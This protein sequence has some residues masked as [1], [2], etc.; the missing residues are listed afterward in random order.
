MGYSAS[1]EDNVQMVLPSW[2]PPQPRGLLT[3]IR[4][5]AS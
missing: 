2:L 3:L 4:Y 1:P 5:R